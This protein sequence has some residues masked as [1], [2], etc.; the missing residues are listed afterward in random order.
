MGRLKYDKIPIWENKDRIKYLTFF[1]D[2]WLEGT[3]AADQVL[4]SPATGKPF[5]QEERRS[6]LNRRIPAVKEMVALADIP[7]LRDWVTIRKDDELV[8]VDILEQFW[9]TDKL[10]LSYRA[11]S[12]VVDEAIGKY[13]TDQRA[14]WVRTFNPLYWLGRLIDWLIGKAFNVVS[15]FGG[16]PRAARNSPVGRTVFAIGTFLAWF[17]TMG[18]FTIAAL[19]F[20][21]FKTPVRQFLH[22]P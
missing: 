19:D 2:L 13:Q 16:N 3:F 22:L 12:D 4:V 17:A 15:L 7:T 14:S 1:R 11:P 5:R 18:G 8:R 6:E 10:R 21:G 9:Y 20:L